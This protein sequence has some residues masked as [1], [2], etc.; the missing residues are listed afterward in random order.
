[1]ITSYLT[2]L[3]GALSIAY[4]DAGDGQ[5]ARPTSYLLGEAEHSAGTT[6]YF[7]WNG[8]LERYREQ[9]K[10]DPC[11]KEEGECKVEKWKKFLAT[12][13]DSP[14]EDQLRAVNDYANAFP[15][16]TDKEN[17]GGGNYWET[18][19]QFLEV[20][21]NCKDYAIFKYY[22]L[23]MLGVPS[24]KLRL[25]VLDDLMSGGITHAVL[26]VYDDKGELLILDNIITKVA[27]ARDISFYRP[28]YA[29]NERSSW[30]YKHWRDS[31]PGFNTLVARMWN[32]QKNSPVSYAALN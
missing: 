13:K 21:G 28:I 11:A 5:V 17:W 7:R 26:G 18:P 9:Q 22:S 19:Y 27:R 2:L 4:S 23:R 32:E 3:L 8:M 12:I 25:I 14:L 6:P 20:S 16:V 30:L 1:M 31:K 10:Q 24:S 15:Y 29:V